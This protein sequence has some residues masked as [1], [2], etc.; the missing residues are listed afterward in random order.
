MNIVGLCVSY[1]YMDTL[2]FMLPVNHVHF[3]CIY[4]V[5][6]EDDTSTIEFC[7]QFNNVKVVFFNFKN[8]NKTFDKYG[9]LNVIQTIAYKEHP[10]C[11]YLNIDSDI[12]LPTNFKTLLLSVNLHRNCIYGCLRINCIKSSDMHN[13]D[14]NVS[15]YP[16]N[17]IIYLQDRP[18]CVIGY[19]QLY[20]QKIFHRANLTNAS[21]GDLCFGHDNFN[22]F[23]N[24]NMMC[25]HL[26]ESCKNWN[27][28][29]INFNIDDPSINASNFS[30]S[31]DINPIYYNKQKKIINPSQM[32]DDVK[33]V[34]NNKKN[35]H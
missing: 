21:E 29:T 17:N 20:K 22:Y 1:Q 18:P 8:N 14:L 24:L 12:I 32:I 16:F 23:S 6:Q 13:L 33:M 27:G 5:T 4:I 11:W 34:Y 2:Q 30:F 31:C 3:R 7:K 26:G 19:F 28:K 35:T 15:T 10:E 9:G 25:I